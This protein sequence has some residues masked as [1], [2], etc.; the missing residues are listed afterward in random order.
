M[1]SLLSLYDDIRQSY[2]N[3]FYVARLDN[4]VFDNGTYKLYDPYL[5]KFISDNRLFEKEYSSNSYHI[6]EVSEPLPGFNKKYS[7]SIYNIIQN[8]KKIESYYKNYRI[9]RLVNLGYYFGN[10]RLEYKQIELHGNDDNVDLYNEEYM[11]LDIIPDANQTFINNTSIADET[12]INDEF[13]IEC[14]TILEIPYDFDLVL[15]N[16]NK[17][18]SLYLNGNSIN[19]CTKFTLQNLNEVVLDY[20]FRYF[21]YTPMILYIIKYLIDNIKISN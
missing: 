13:D 14:E 1:Q 18:I 5:I 3:E 10:G 20:N 7:K 9:L 21:I 19:T 2:L 17:L 12:L 11:K 6:L 15:Y 16:F 8:K 4:F